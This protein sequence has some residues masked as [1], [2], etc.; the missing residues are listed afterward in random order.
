MNLADK[1]IINYIESKK[2]QEE[3]Y[4]DFKD[5]ISKDSIYSSHSY[6]A[7]MVPD[8]QA[9][10]IDVVLQNDPSIK[11]IFDPYMGSRNNINRRIMQKFKHNWY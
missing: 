10:L 8:M 9:E 5:T 7:K 4:W 2:K 3:T 1:N 11:N 6:P